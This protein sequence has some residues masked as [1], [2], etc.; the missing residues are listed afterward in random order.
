[1]FP[2]HNLCGCRVVGGRFKK[3]RGMRLDD[4]HKFFR[5]LKLKDVPLSQCE[6]AYSGKHD[7]DRLYWKK[8]DTGFLAHAVEFV[9]CP[10]SDCD[11]WDD[12]E[13]V[14]QTLFTVIAYFDGVRH[15]EF[16]R[17]GNDMDGYLYYPPMESLIAMLSKVRE[18]ELKHCGDAD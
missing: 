2:G 3:D 12:K 8:T 4:D 5:D 18:L 10:D 11:Q 14:V 6:L 15:L 9:S 1:M 17:N 16:N 13:L 7:D